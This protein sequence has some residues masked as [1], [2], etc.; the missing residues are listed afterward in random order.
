VEDVCF[1]EREDGDA[2]TREEEVVSGA[3]EERGE[4]YEG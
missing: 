4:D 1:G 3:D 2:E